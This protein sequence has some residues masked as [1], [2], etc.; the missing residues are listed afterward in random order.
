MVDPNESGSSLERQRVD[1]R[2]LDKKV[3]SL[4][5]T[6]Q[7]LPLLSPQRLPQMSTSRHTP[8]ATVFGP[9][10]RGNPPR[11]V[12]ERLSRRIC[13]RAIFTLIFR[14]FSQPCHPH[15]RS[16]LSLFP[17]YPCSPPCFHAIDLLS[18]SRLSR[19]FMT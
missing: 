15:I 3:R 9:G 2:K 19:T 12:Y 16:P 5:E 8:G 18:Y 6:F 10:I 4:S 13:H 17:C 14:P 11:A 1:H 7:Q